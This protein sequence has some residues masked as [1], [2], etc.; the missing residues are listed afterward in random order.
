MDV[1]VTVTADDMAIHDDALLLR[2]LPG[3]YTLFA[4]TNS[5]ATYQNTTITLA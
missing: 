2:V 4:G 5:A 1:A 3:T